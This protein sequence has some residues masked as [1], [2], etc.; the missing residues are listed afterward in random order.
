MSSSLGFQCRK[1]GSV[2]LQFIF[3]REKLSPP[4]GAMSRGCWEARGRRWGHSPV[5][6]HAHGQHPPPLLWCHVG[7][8]G[9][10]PQRRGQ[11][12]CSGPCSWPPSPQGTRSSQW[13][14]WTWWTSPSGSPTTAKQNTPAILLYR[15]WLEGPRSCELFKLFLFFLWRCRKGRGIAFHYVN[16]MKPIEVD[17]QMKSYKWLPGD[18]FTDISGTWIWTVKTLSK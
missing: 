16:P 14:P 15:K 6:D 1:K 13:G 3:I 9:P 7:A 12:T 17:F 8:E 5:L 11:L 4:P 18:C 10:G 2:A